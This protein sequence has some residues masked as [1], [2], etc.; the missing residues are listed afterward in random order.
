MVYNAFR[1]SIHYVTNSSK[2][3]INWTYKKNNMIKKR[4]SIGVGF[5]F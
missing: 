4:L 3:L 1:T 2:H 5:N